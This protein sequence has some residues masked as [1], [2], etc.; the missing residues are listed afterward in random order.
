MLHDKISDP[1]TAALGGY[2][3]LRTGELERLHSWPAN[4]ADWMEWISDGPIIRAWQLLRGGTPRSGETPRRRLLEAAQRGVP[5]YSEGLR[6]L[7]DGLKV[8]GRADPEDTEVAAAIDRMGAYAAVADWSR[9]VLTFTAGS[10]GEP[11]GEPMPV[12]RA[13]DEGTLMLYSVTIGDLVKRRLLRAGTRL[14]TAPRPARKLEA[15]FTDEMVITGAGLLAEVPPGAGADWMGG[16]WQYGDPSQALVATQPGMMDG[17]QAWVTPDGDTLDTLR[18]SARQRAPA[19]EAEP[20]ELPLA[21]QGI[22]SRAVRALGE[23]GLVTVADLLAFGL[24]NVETIPGV[25]PSLADGVRRAI[26]ERGLTM[27]EGSARRS[28]V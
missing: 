1:N 26:G 16:Y 23:A 21:D 3:L 13:G 11:T 4:L 5:I 18:R 10:P 27:V 12:G 8:V 24:D 15:A 2:Y 7:I 9:A 25:G 20:E 6:L 28:Q 14:R 19:D 22:P 17:W